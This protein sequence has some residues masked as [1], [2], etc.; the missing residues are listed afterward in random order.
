MTSKF[1]GLNRRAFITTTGA[2]LATLAG[3]LARPTLSRAADRP[4][5]THGLQSGDVS[6]DSAVVWTRADRPSR[7]LIEAAPTDSFKDVLHAAFVD[8]LPESDFTAKALLPTLPAGQDIFYR[9]TLQNLAEPT[10]RGEPTV[11]RFRTAPAD[12]RSVSFGFS[13]G[14]DFRCTDVDLRDFTSVFRFSAT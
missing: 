14:A 6:D 8:A 2:G 4:R 7:V 9:V 5:I 3:G 10:I 13:P 11:G 1:R 12:R